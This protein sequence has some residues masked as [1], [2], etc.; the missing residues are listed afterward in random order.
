MNHPCPTCG[1]AVLIADESLPTAFP[2]CSSRCR[3]R[4]LGA[5]LDERHVVAGKPLDTGYGHD[6]DVDVDHP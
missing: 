3:L 1:A 2:F 6:L 4:D 5:W